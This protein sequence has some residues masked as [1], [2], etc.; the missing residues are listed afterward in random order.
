MR[1]KLFVFSALLFVS[2][3]TMGQVDSLI[4]NKKG[5]LILPQKGDY[6][7]GI[8]TNS[9]FDYL[10]NMFT[11][12]GSNSLRLNL[13]NGTTLYSKYFL[14]AETAIRAKIMISANF[15]ERLEPRQNQWNQIIYSPVNTSYYNVNITAGYEKRKGSGRIQFSWGPEVSLGT[16]LNKSKGMG[17]QDSKNIIP[18]KIGARVFG[19][20]E[21]FLMPKISIGGEIG[22]GIYGDILGKTELESADGDDYDIVEYNN[23]SIGTDI[24]GGQIILLIHF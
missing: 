17:F 2:L 3:A 18:L 6:A 23:W 11:D 19:G 8:S 24:L 4:T 10:G 22:F 12:D 5:N 16:Y 15:N 14:S 20:A 1:S 13:L 7:I 21:Y 9:I